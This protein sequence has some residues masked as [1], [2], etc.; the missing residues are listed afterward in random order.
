MHNF[1]H[2]YRYIFSFLLRRLKHAALKTF[3]SHFSP[4]KIHLFEFNTIAQKKIQNFEKPKSMLK[5]QK[6]IPE[7]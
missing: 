7:K 3:F 6:N 2:C 4:I 5:K 1:L